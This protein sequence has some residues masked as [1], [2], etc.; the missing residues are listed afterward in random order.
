M[1]P[2]VWTFSVEPVEVDVH[3]SCAGSVSTECCIDMIVLCQSWS[4][5]YM[6]LLGIECVQCILYG[7]GLAVALKGQSV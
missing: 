4:L 5:V 7:P 6:Q 1:L 2:K 3:K